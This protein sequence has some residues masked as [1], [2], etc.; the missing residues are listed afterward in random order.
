MIFFGWS[1]D[2]S[3]G[4]SSAYDLSLTDDN[5]SA[6]AYLSKY[7]FKDIGNRL[8]GRRK[9]LYSRGLKKPSV[10]KLSYGTN[11]YYNYI[12]YL[13][14]RTELLESEEVTPNRKYGV[15]FFKRNI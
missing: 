10:L 11:E 13:E 6:A 2:N 12:A 3:L 5:F 14:S 9:I 15:P 1:V 4:Y 7:F 8:W